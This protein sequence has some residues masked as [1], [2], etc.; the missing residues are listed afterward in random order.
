[1]AVYMKKK[2]N[3]L[4]TRDSGELTQEQVDQLMAEAPAFKSGDIASLP[5][6]ENS[7]YSISDDS[8][9]KSLPNIH[10]SPTHDEEFDISP[11]DR[12]TYTENPN[13]KKN[14]RINALMKQVYT[15]RESGN[16]NEAERLLKKLDELIASK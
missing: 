10:L 12:A 2:M 5:Q 11:R 8:A 9:R 14:N 16:R 6:S 13:S 4:S 15:A 3:Q 7:S 1:M